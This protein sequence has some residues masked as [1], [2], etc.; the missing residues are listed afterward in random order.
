MPANEPSVAVMTQIQE[1]VSQNF[2]FNGMIIRD[3]MV[4]MR[5]SSINLKRSSEQAFML[6][7]MTN[8]ALLQ[9]IMEREGNAELTSLLKHGDQYPT[10][11]AG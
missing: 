7:V 4:Q 6:G 3:Q 2:G 8:M 11:Q 10:G 1:A 9:N 5:D